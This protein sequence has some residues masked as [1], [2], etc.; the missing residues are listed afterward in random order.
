MLSTG[1]NNCSHVVC[2]FLALPSGH[3]NR[4]SCIA[5]ADA[6]QT[7]IVGQQFIQIQASHF[8]DYKSKQAT[9]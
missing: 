2:H 3:L 4:G 7:R 8:V 9:L 1:P 5:L 6:G